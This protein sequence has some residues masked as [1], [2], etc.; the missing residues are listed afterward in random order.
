MPKINKE[1]EIF[2][3]EAV[4]II[5]GKQFEKM[6]DLL[7]SDKHVNEFI[8]AKK[9]DITINQARNLLYKISDHGLVSSIRKKDKKKG[10]YTYF[11]K[12][13]NLKSLEFLENLTNKKMEQINSQIK[14][15]EIK[16]FYYCEKC[17]IEYSEENALLHDFTCPECGGVFIIKDNSK[18]VKDL[19]RSLEKLDGEMKILNQEIEY[20][21]AKSNVRRAKDNSKLLKQKTKD[22]AL[23]RKVRSVEK[24]KMK[25]KPK[26]E[27]KNKKKDK[28]KDKKRAKKKDKKRAKSS[29]KKNSSKK[30][31]V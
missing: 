26:Y 20:E 28:K 18:V 1:L 22:R 21:K 3:K 17:N 19:K 2:L 31:R 15:R 5:I 24:H 7:N 29:S 14:S 4:S 12:L 30:K 13:E 25:E 9:L 27:S 23:A 11:W 16:Q 8:I 10:W 6:A